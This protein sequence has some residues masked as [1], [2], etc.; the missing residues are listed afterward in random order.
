MKEE[1]IIREDPATI[2]E[3]VVFK[4][5]GYEPVKETVEAVLI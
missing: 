5:N 4:V 2:D 3:V 1:S